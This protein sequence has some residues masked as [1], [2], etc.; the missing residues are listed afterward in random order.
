MAKVD[1]DEARSVRVANFGCGSDLVKLG[2]QAK[3]VYDFSIDLAVL[4]LLARQ[5]QYKGPQDVA[6]GKGLYF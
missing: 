6:D 5:M 2:G 4:D 3:F 1:V